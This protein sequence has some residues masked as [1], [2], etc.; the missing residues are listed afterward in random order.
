MVILRRELER[1]RSNVFVAPA[2]HGAQALR[3][4]HAQD[5]IAYLREISAT[6]P[7]GQD[8]FPA[9]WPPMSSKAKPPGPLRI[10]MGYY[11]SDTGTPLTRAAYDAALAAAEC[12]LTGAELVLA[13][14][15]L[16]YA[17][18]RPP[19]HHA[20]QRRAAGL[21]FFNNTAL[22]AKLLSRHGRVATLDIDFHHGNGTQELFYRSN[23]VLTTSVHGAPEIAFPFYSGWA[24]ETGAGNGKG[25]NLNVP[26]PKE[27]NAGQY[28]AG[29]AKALRK[30]KAFH[31]KYLV[32]ALGFDTYE[33]DPNGGFIGMTTDAY[34]PVGR[35]IASLGVPTLLVQEG[36]YNLEALGACARGFYE[37]LAG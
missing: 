12:A 26:L 30:I 5:Y 29:L 35:D 2:R 3:A 4:L 15:R 18:V 10:R 19:G 32:V 27:T 17:L 8:S 14:E 20:E 1:S 25:Y 23:R 24:N 7:P 37:G 36:G 16:A 9:V 31:P 13:G 28:R 21:C 6:I 22:A 34:E 33:K 11:I